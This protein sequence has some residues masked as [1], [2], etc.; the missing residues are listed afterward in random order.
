M[1]FLIKKSMDISLYQQKLISNPLRLK[2]IYLLSDQSMTAKQVASELGKTPGS[3]HYHIQQLYKGGILEIEE[4]KE[5]KGIIEK[6]YRSKANQFNL[7]QGIETN[8]DVE[9]HSR[10][11][12]L[13]LTKKELNEFEEDLDALFLKYLKKSV[14][15]ND[16]TNN[17]TSYEIICLFK[18]IINEEEK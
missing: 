13:S 5:Y 7:K 9:T 18:K 8:D 15:S 3:V 12:S 10:A 4:T 2:I 14:K 1:D 17:R 16:N 6:Y 11:T